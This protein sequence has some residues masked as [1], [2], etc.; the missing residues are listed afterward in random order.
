MRRWSRRRGFTLFELL[1]VVAILFIVSALTVPSFVKSIKGNR[2]RA[3]TRSVV[4]AGRF[5]RSMAVL[6]QREMRVTFDLSAS[7]LEVRTVEAPVNPEPGPG[8]PTAGP[9]GVAVEPLPPPALPVSEPATNRPKGLVG[10][11]VTRKLDRVTILQVDTDAEGGIARTAGRQDVIYYSN[12]RCV[13]YEVR[14]KDEEGS[15]ATVRVDELSSAEVE[16]EW[17]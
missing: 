13:P 1:L 4:M 12:G 8:D 16:M 5:A 17:H 7:S 3:A 15:V 2:L 9:A 6:Q 14:L 11:E 10:N